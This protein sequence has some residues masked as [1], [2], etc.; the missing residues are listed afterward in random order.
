MS[1]VH[2]YAERGPSRQDV[3]SLAGATLLEFG[4]LWCGHCRRA[5]SL[6]EEAFAA[7]GSVR[8]IRIADSSGRRLGRSFGVKLWPTLIFLK[9]GKEISRLIRPTDLAAVHK[10]FQDIDEAPPTRSRVGDG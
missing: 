3:D 9:D 2:E 6:I 8:H 1:F 4:N 5:E 10:A 7:H